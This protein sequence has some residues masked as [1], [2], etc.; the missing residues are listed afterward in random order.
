M[1]G[2]KPFFFIVIG[3]VVFAATLPAQASLNKKKGPV[4]TNAVPESPL[5]EIGKISDFQF[6]ERS[7]AA[8]DS[9]EL[10]GK[11]WI[12]SFMFTRCAGICPLMS[13]HMRMLQEKLKYKG[14][15]RFV[16]FSVDPEYDTPEV[17][18]KYAE[19]FNAD[20]KKWFFLTGPKK[21]IFDLSERAFR[22]GV[23]EIPEK[24]REAADQSVGHSA[25]F[26][27]VDQ[28]GIIRGYY[29]SQSMKD[30]DPLISAVERLL[31]N[32]P[33]EKE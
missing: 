31:L 9:K 26:V 25:R 18:R 7:G 6:T 21:E 23:G 16:S 2:L 24:D 8:F 1:N 12:A 30:F 10:K 3:M 11:V 20:A 5:P 32:P 19:R 15:V 28:R 22:L 4:P 27:L 13:N 17:L 14:Q 29:D 33:Q